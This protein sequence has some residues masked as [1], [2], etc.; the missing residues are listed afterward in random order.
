ML[1]GV[2]FHP[3]A[4][5]QAKQFLNTW[6]F[7]A[8]ND[9]ESVTILD[10]DLYSVTKHYVENFIRMNLVHCYCPECKSLHNQVLIKDYE[11]SGYD[12]NHWHEIWCCPR[13]HIIYEEMQSVRLI[14]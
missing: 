12:K 11:A 1:K 9:D 7:N 14:F 8:D 6:L 13:H 4:H 10:S 2:S 5:D 3:L